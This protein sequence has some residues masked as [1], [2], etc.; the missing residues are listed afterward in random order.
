MLNT[1][2]WIHRGT[3]SYVVSL[4][5]FSLFIFLQG[6]S[7]NFYL[8]SSVSRRFCVFVAELAILV[9]LNSVNAVR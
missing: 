7:A 8:I 9:G 6:S 3:N 2:A 5:N 4:S 1:C